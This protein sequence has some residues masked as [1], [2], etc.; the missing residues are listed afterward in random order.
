MRDAANFRTA[1][2]VVTDTATSSLFHLLSVC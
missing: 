1:V 2:P